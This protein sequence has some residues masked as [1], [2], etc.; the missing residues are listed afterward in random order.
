LKTWYDERTSLPGPAFWNAVLFAESARCARFGRPA[1]VVLVEIV[2]LREEHGPWGSEVAPADLVEISA[3][4]ANGCRASDY[5]ARLDG[6]R[7]GIV[8]TE[9]DEIAA[10]N[11]VERLRTRVDDLL[12]SRMAPARVAFGWASPK[13][14]LTLVE[15]VGRAEIRLRHEAQ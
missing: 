1:T 3:A 13:G 5:V 2:V 10:I 6:P 7:F 8:L 11:V 14:E 9:T 12:R 4:L 15:A